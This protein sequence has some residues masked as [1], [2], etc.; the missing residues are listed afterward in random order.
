MIIGVVERDLLERCGLA[1]ILSEH[2]R[3][4]VAV[5][6]SVAA[7]LEDAPP[8]SL[9][10]LVADVRSYREHAR[11][12]SGLARSVLVLSSSVDE[13]LA[14]EVLSGQT[15]GVLLRPISS[16]QAL[17][18]AIDSLAAGAPKLDLGLVRVLLAAERL[19]V[20]IDG[21]SG[22]RHEVLRLVAAGYTDRAIADKLFVSVKTIQADVHSIFVKLRI[23]N[24]E[25]VNR[26]VHATLAWHQRHTPR[27]GDAT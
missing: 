12:C 7:M 2:G 10:V 20:A 25:H 17:L 22:R 27:P 9:D 4:V 24:G 1:Q 11:L 6:G 19:P 18:G 26:R 13:T 3:E 14:A 8:R 21:L 5:H 15:L 16:P 23:P